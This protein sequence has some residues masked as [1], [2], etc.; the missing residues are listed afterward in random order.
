MRF[1]F[2]GVFVV[3]RADKLDNR[4][5]ERVEEDR[6]EQDLVEVAD[7]KEMVHAG[8]RYLRAIQD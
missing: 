2:A 6:K 5:V 8:K 3:V 4:P 1:E 7:T